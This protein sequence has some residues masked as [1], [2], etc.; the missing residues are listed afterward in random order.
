MTTLQRIQETYERDL[1]ANFTRDGVRKVAVNPAGY[2]FPFVENPNVPDGE[3][4]FVPQDFWQ[5][6]DAVRLF[7][8]SNLGF[9]D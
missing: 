1:E 7:N 6:E 9:E 4:W 5:R 3:V 2:P 8:L